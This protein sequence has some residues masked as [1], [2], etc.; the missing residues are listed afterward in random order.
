MAMVA[1]MA[2]YVVYSL[3]ASPRPRA[4]SFLFVSAP[5]PS[6]HTTTHTRWGWRS[7]CSASE[8]EGRVAEGRTSLE[9]KLFRGRVG[10]KRRDH[11]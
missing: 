11:I 8:L 3:D 9:Q 5:L 7:R 2:S 6:V 4:P 10:C 1:G